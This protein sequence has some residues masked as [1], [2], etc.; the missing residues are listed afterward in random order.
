MHQ[1]VVPHFARSNAGAE[2]EAG[3]VRDAVAVAMA[4]AVAVVVAM[5]E[6][7]SGAETEGAT[8]MLAGSCFGVHAK[9]TRARRLIRSG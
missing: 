1:G 3:S 9:K 5:A 8:E 6:A 2:V 4:E 7:V